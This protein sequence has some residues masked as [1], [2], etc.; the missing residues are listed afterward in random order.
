M[1]GG[2]EPGWGELDRFAAAPSIGDNTGWVW[3]PPVGVFRRVR[4]NAGAIPCIST[5]YS[6]C[7]LP[8]W[9]DPWLEWAYSFVC[10]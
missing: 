10:K 1:P 6:M 7:R 5:L 4:I 3:A 9:G 2:S 8:L